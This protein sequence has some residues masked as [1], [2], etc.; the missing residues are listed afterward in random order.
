MDPKMCCD[1]NKFRD[2]ISNNSWKYQA[3]SKETNLI[4]TR[5]HNQISL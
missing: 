5:K 4:E 3:L 1:K 2:I